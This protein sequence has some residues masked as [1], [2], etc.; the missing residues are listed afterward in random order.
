MALHLGTAKA[1]VAMLKEKQVTP[2]QLIDAA[3]QQITATEHLVRLKYTLKTPTPPTTHTFRP[4]RTTSTHTPANA[5][6]KS[7]PNSHPTT[8]LTTTHVTATAVTK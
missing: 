6:R 1:M 5:P 3:E 2:L 7:H 8:S 4:P